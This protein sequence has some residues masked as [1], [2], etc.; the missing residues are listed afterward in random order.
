MSSSEHVEL[1]EAVVG[2]LRAL[3]SSLGTYIAELE[4][5]NTAVVAPMLK[6]ANSEDCWRASGFAAQIP[7]ARYAALCA[8]AFANVQAF[9]GLHRPLFEAAAAAAATAA[10][11][12]DGRTAWFP[13]HFAPDAIAIANAPFAHASVGAT[14]A[15]LLNQPFPSSAAASSASASASDAGSEPVTQM[16]AALLAFAA[17]AN[18]PAARA[19]GD[20][21]A[22]VS[23]NAVAALETVRFSLRISVKF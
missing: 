16:L 6:L 3:A 4:G 9:S 7:R 5:F 23:C 8:D 2:Q 18:G 14:A 1:S 21:G 10:T 15:A 22:L 20:F 13:L 11:A 12:G 17:P 19:Y